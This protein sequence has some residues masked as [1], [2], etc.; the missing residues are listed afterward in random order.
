MKLSTH[1]RAKFW[2]VILLAS[3]GMHGCTSSPAFI[4]QS[5]S[6]SNVPSAASP[7]SQALLGTWK[8]VSL[9]YE[10][11]DGRAPVS[12]LGNNPIG[13]MVLSPAGRMAAVLEGE[14]RKPAKTDEERSALLRSLISYT[15]KY[16]I[17]GDRWITKVDA[18]WN[19]AWN[20]TE[21]EREFRLEGDKLFV[22]SM[23]QPNS[24]MPGNPEAHA[25]MQWEREK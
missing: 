24:T 15:G 16:R 22:I 25:I 6:A 13:Y 4:N 14:G 5:P 8:L 17:E 12:L 10:F 20:G 11:R 7:N 2:P 19:G 21:Q 3:L 23:W 9:V 18:S 1:N